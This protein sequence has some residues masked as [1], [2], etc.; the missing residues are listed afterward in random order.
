[1]QTIKVPWY[2]TGSQLLSLRYKATIPNATEE[3]NSHSKKKSQAIILAQTRMQ[4][5]LADAGSYTKVCKM[6]KS[7]SC[8]C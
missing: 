3:P 7:S 5:T 8:C 2:M 4:N 1:M 6:A